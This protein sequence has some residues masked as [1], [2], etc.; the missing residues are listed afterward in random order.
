MEKERRIYPRIPVNPEFV[1]VVQGDGFFVQDLS[2]SG[3]FVRSEEEHPVGS[4]LRLR[5]SVMVDD[6]CVF[7]VKG[8]VTRSNS[9]SHPSG[10]GVEFVELEPET[11]REIER[12]LH[13]CKL[14][15]SWEEGQ[16]VTRQDWDEAQ[17]ALR[18]AAASA[19]EFALGAAPSPPKRPQEDEVTRVFYYEGKDDP[20]PR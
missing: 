13:L 5:F 4:L 10:F 11:K 3:V 15:H 8:R 1:P 20:P 6:V 19:V 16:D 12:V 17:R 18:P 2:P 7:D 9:Q 14:R